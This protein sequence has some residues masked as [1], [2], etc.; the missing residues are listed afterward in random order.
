MTSETFTFSR[1]DHAPVK[2]IGR[3]A[4]ILA[5]GTA[6]SGTAMAGPCD[7]LGE[8]VSRRT[9]AEIIRTD[10]VMG[11]IFFRHPAAHEMWLAC[12]GAGQEKQLD[13]ADIDFAYEGKPD[14]RFLALVSVAGAMVIDRP[15]P[16][17][18]LGDCLIQSM[19]DPSGQGRQESGGVL[20]ECMFVGPDGDVALSRAEGDMIS[21][22]RSYDQKAGAATR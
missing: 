17:A 3:I 15:I 6:L 8:A 16:I 14:A 5:V 9:H 13:H 2:L 10:P 22:R 21:P 19:I 18:A 11:D 12:G 4:A 1:R 20:F 7:A